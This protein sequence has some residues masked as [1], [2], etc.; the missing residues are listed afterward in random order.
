MRA[1]STCLVSLFV[2]KACIPRM[3][4]F[5]NSVQ[6]PNPWFPQRTLA[7]MSSL[8]LPLSQSRKLSDEVPH[9]STSLKREIDTE[10]IAGNRDISQELSDLYEQLSASWSIVVKD[11]LVRLVR[12]IPVEGRGNISIVFHCQDSMELD[13][14]MLENDQEDIEDERSASIQFD[15]YVSRH[16]KT[17]KITCTTQGTQVGVDSLVVFD[18]G[19]DDETTDEENKDQYRGP[20]LEELPVN[21]QDGISNFV[22]EEGG[23]NE[24]MVAFISMYADYL[25]QVQYEKWLKDVQKIVD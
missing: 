9:L 1:Q 13:D 22:M 19:V 21:M 16:N 2:R 17:M 24:D 25:E 4:S 15:L 20:H 3:A 5:S 14:G 6:R 7:D 18:G 12:K 23:V 11:S 8:D 10:N